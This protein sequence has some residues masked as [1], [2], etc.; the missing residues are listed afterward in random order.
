MIEWIKKDVL[1]SSISIKRALGKI[2]NE[3]MITFR[4]DLTEL[5]E[6]YRKIKAITFIRAQGFSEEESK[7]F[8][9]SAKNLDATQIANQLLLS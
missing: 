9:L 4:Q 3:K 5:H 8:N 6:C 7:V 2:S 1:P